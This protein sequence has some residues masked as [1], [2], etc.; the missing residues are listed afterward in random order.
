MQEGLKPKKNYYRSRLINLIAWILNGT[1]IKKTFEERVDALIEYKSKF[2]NCNV[3][4]TVTS[5]YFTL[6]RWVTR[7]RSAYRQIQEGRPLYRPL[8]QDQID[9]LDRIG[10]EWTM[11]MTF[12][13]RFDEL[14][15][16]KKEHGHCTPPPMRPSKYVSLAAWCI[17]VRASYRRIQEGEAPRKPL[18]PDHIDHLDR[19]GFEWVRVG[20]NTTKGRTGKRRKK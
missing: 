9:Q 7:Q 6:A 8:T 14:V 2:G 20:P 12:E 17:E 16:F 10:M 15:A 4:Q 19:L 1:V 5:E 13:E 3:P 11:K 18:T